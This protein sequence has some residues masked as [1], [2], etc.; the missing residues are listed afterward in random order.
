MSKIELLTNLKSYVLNHD[1]AKFVYYC[2]KKQSFCSI[3]HLLHQKNLFIGNGKTLNLLDNG[4]INDALSEFSER[5]LYYIQLFNDNVEKHELVDL[6]E[7]LISGQKITDF[8]LYD[9]T[10]YRF[11]TGK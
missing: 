3:G 6:L 1:Y 4:E 11:F 5:E 2:G 8:Y 7:H 10:E 9:E